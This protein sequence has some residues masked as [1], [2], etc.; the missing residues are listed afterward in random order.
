MGRLVLAGGTGILGQLLIPSFLEKGYEIVVLTRQVQC[1]SKH[2]NVKYV[3]WD[4]RQSGEWTNYLDGADVLINLSGERIDRRFTKKNRFLLEKSRIEPTL[5]L[6]EAI[7]R[8]SEPPDIWI[9]FS[10]VS[11]FAGVSIISDE[12][13]HSYGHGFLADLTK[14]WEEAFA[15]Y[16]TPK[17]S[18]IIL[19]ISPVLTERG[20]LFASLYPL[21]KWG[22][23][24]TVGS[25]KQYVSWIHQED[26]VRLLH[27]LIG[28]E[29][30]QDIYHACAPGVISNQQLMQELRNAS[31]VKV[32][33]PLS[34]V[35]AKIG[36]YLQGIDPSLLLET[37]PVVSTRLVEE[38]FQF[39]YPHIAGALNQLVSWI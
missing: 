22:L 25:G 33:L 4:G 23:A 7:S 10:G 35:F 11:I 36:A 26:F 16:D 38:G 31:G 1:I 21:A 14:K 2:E 18:K 37:T 13:S 32:G 9:N 12:Y 6:G 34:T 39:K 19:R 17:T 8:L 30:K 24:G 5:A 29:K 15:V 27:W 3:Y 28:G 20:G